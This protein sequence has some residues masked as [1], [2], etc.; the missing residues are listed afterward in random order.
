MEV[1]QLLTDIDLVI[2][3]LGGVLYEIEFQRTID[4][5]SALPGY[6][7]APITFGVDQ[8]DD[9]FVRAD[10]GDCTEQAFYSTL[11]ARFG[12]TCSDADLERAWCAI[13]IG[14][15]GDA[16]SFLDRVRAHRPLALL[17]NISTPHLRH[18][19]P[20]MSDI[21]ARVDAAF[22]SCQIGLRK[23][24]PAAFLHVTTS[25]HADPSRTLLIDDSS[26]NCMAA[27]GLGMRT[28]HFTRE[29]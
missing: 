1:L 10:R 15:Y 9:I 14:P 6:N 8:Q 4:A 19:M 7:G 17:S 5:L 26:A 22:Y 12:F 23:P 28:W 21:L 29:A 11:R 24:D 16:A 13:L 3:D 20:M 18:A 2:F 27:R 25:M